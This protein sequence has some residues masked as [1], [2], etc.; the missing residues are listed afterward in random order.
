MDLRQFL[1][2]MPVLTQ[3]DAEDGGNGRHK[4]SNRGEIN[5]SSGRGGFKGHS[6]KFKNHQKLSAPHQ[7]NNQNQNP[8]TNPTHRPNDTCHRCGRSEHWSRTCHTP[9]EVVEQYKVYKAFVHLTETNN[10]EC[11]NWNIMTPEG[12]PIDITNLET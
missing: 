3:T 12:P 5:N 9:K 4:S 7:K 1:K 11:W 2:Q 10:L 6:P 8:L